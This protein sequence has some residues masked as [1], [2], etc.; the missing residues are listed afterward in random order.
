MPEMV[1]RM[2]ASR[3]HRMKTHQITGEG[4]SLEWHWENRATRHLIESRNWNYVVLQDRSGG[5]LEAKE[6]MF[7]HARLLDEKIKNQ[8]AK[9][10]FFMTW[11]SWKK[12]D[13]QETIA[14]AYLQITRELCA[15]IAPVGLAW[16]RALRKDPGL[17]LHH[18]DGRHA[19]PVGSYLAA[20]VFYATFFNIS[21]EG[22]PG[23]LFVAGKERVNLSRPMAGFLQE[24][25]RDAV[26]RFT[27]EPVLRTLRNRK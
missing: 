9:T 13:T 23:N 16:E 22:L 27:S 8:G 21:P 3:R 1:E 26:M 11:A 25:A 7:V 10:I 24:I 17:D 5:P 6:P 20:C 2:A 4:A 14:K 19:N 12:P 18:K 15:I